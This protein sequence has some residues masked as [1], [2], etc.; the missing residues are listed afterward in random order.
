M[1]APKL[2]I[3]VKSDL[4]PGQQAVQGCHAAIQF[5][6]E[7]LWTAFKWFKNSNHIAFLSVPSEL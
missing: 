2:Y 4:K 3:V 5:I 7:H 1:G 6:Y